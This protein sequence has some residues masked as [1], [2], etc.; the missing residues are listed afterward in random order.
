MKPSN[1]IIAVPMGDPSGIGPEIVLKA[2]KDKDLLEKRIVVVGDEGI[3]STLCKKTHHPFPFSKVVSS[4]SEVSL[5]LKEGH[6]HI[7]LNLDLVDL[8]LFRYKVID[9]M[10]GKAAY[11]SIVGAVELATL[12][13]VDAIATTPIQK[14][15][16][17]AAGIKAI[18]HTEILG[19]LTH[20]SHP[21]TMF[22]THSLHIFFMTRHL[23]LRDACD[24]VTRERVY[25]FIKQ[26]DAITKSDLF[27]SHTPLAV[28]A[29]NPHGGEHG[30]FGDEE[31]KEI[32]PAIQRAQEEGIDVVGPIGADS[33]FHMAKIGRF[34]AVLSL[35]HD[36]G[37]IA[38][39]T[40]DFEK[41][42]SVTW[43][44]P[45]IRT[46]VDHGTALD[47]A[48]ENKASEVSMIEAIKVAFRYI[49][50]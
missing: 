46:S 4:V 26:V 25:D 13:I 19:E 40:L 49:E 22:E 30:L 33:V 17:K 10:S 43:N 9:G 50:R 15:S 12:H 39:K 5:A 38:A 41:T 32:I 14:E 1:K 23:S 16:L 44:L 35:Y 42:I 21:V 11:E 37:H 31:M 45:F 48:G 6:S 20:S 7:L 36:Q 34:K 27:D 3:F 8:S 29:L 18:G 24:A 47:I 28:A 2:L